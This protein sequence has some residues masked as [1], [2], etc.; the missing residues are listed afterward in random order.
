[1]SNQTDNM[2]KCIHHVNSSQYV[3]NMKQHDDIITKST[4]LIQGVDMVSDINICIAIHFLAPI[5]TYVK[6]RVLNRAIDIVQT[7]NDDFNNYSTNSNTMNNFRYKTIINQVFISNMS[8]QKIYLGEDYLKLLPIS[9]SNITFE[10]GEIYYY[11][12]KNQLCLKQSDGSDVIKQYIYQHQA[13]AIKPDKILNLWIVDMTDTPI[14]GFS[15]FPWEEID[16]YHG[17]VVHR[18]VF[19]PEDYSETKFNS[20]KTFTHEI[21]HYLGLLHVF[22]QVSETDTNIGIECDNTCTDTKSIDNIK[23][24][25]QISATS[26]PLDKSNNK[27]LHFDNMFC[28]LFMNFMDYTND[29]YV[30]M[31]TCNQIK[32]MRYMISTYRP[33]INSL[34]KKFKL[35]SPRYNPDTD[36][37]ISS[38]GSKIL[39]VQNN[40]NML[41]QN[42]PHVNQNNQHIAHLQRIN[43]SQ[44]IG[45]PN[46]QPMSQHNSQPNS[47]PNGQPNGQ[48]NSQPNSQPNGQSMSQSNGQSMSQSI[49]QPM[50]QSNGQYN[51]QSMSQSIGQPGGQQMGQSIGQRMSQST[52]QSIGQPNGQYNSQSMSQS[53]GQPM[54]QSIG[55]SNGQQMGQSP[56]QSISQI[57]GQQMNQ[58]LDQSAHQA[59]QQQILYQQQ[60]LLLQANSPNQT[61]RTEPNRSSQTNNISQLAPN[62]S[63]GSVG[64]QTA[65]SQDQI[66][67]NILKNMPEE[68]NTTLPQATITHTN[69]YENMQK[70]YNSYNSVDG[71]SKSYPYD[72]YTQQHQQQLAMQHIKLQQSQLDGK[73]DAEIILDPTID[74]GMNYQYN[75]TDPRMAQQLNPSAQQYYDPRMMQQSNPSAQ[76]YYDPRMAQQTNPSTQQYYDPRLYQ[77]SN[78][79]TQS[80]QPTQPAQQ[81]Y[82]PRLYQQSN[83]STQPVQQYYDPRLYQQA[84]TSTQP[85]QQYYD[86]RLL[87][88]FNPTGQQTAQTTQPIQY[89]DPRL[90]Q[91]SGVQYYDPRLYQQTH[92]QPKKPQTK[93]SDGQTKMKHDQKKNVVDIVDTDN[94][95]DK[96][97]NTELNLDVVKQ[98]R[99]GRPYSKYSQAKPD[100]KINSLD[101]NHKP[102]PSTLKDI[103][104][105]KKNKII[106]DDDNYNNITDRIDALEQ[107]TMRIPK[108]TMPYGAVPYSTMP[109][110]NS[111]MPVP[112]STMP[113]PLTYATQPVYMQSQQ[114][115]PMYQSLQP[116]QLQQPPQSQ[117]QQFQAPSIFGQVNSKQPVVDQTPNPGRIVPKYAPTD[118]IKKTPILQ[119]AP[120]LLEKISTVDSQL[121]DLKSRI[122]MA[123]SGTVAGSG[124]ATGS[125]PAMGSGPATGSGP[126]LS[127][128]GGSIHPAPA[129]ILRQAAKTDTISNINK[130]NKPP[131]TNYT[132]NN[133]QE[134]MSLIPRRKFVRS[135][136]T[137]NA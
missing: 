20:Y 46:S 4:D 137:V 91:G 73:P 136:P 98:L 86:P 78:P 115:Q 95:T 1:M 62:L 77:Q 89:Y 76:Q 92:Q 8:K 7:I 64:N 23:V 75:Y 110:P 56:H 103:S 94:M 13:A 14:L 121:Q 5:G 33:K 63:G 39:S 88:Q 50:S 10:L 100:T 22:G 29:K 133:T 70:K 43:N 130:S 26:D 126:A 111:T 79:S 30:T 87:Q 114:A 52:G 102:S 84:S 11:P 127:F 9:P 24:L 104:K 48:P 31:F 85:V 82:D 2:R 72:P 41:N 129:Q 119:S 3:Q 93:K 12:V 113:V 99:T 68:S 44:P 80:T 105:T 54:N 58:P 49:G 134:K 106:D 25:T 28:P 38:N 97:D 40:Q 116:Q 81:Y 57:N 35:P 53:I 59:L 32:K 69:T 21:G 37:T 128:T 117:S 18:R 27:R 135:R 132:G 101:P 124:A 109:V 51:S 112:N 131:S 107:M 67:D 71:Y 118:M 65:S 60:Q 83:P 45:Q 34:V 47:Q 6:D 125:G 122:N 19:F 16:N 66:I 108:Y 123:G 96:Y 74:P 120:N 17:I 90:L 15:N 61:Y 36:D 55:Q 42:N